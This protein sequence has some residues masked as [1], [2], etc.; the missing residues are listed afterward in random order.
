MFLD[1]IRPLLEFIPT[2]I[3][4]NMFLAIAAAVSPI[5]YVLIN[6]L[7]FGIEFFASSNANQKCKSKD[8]QK[9]QFYLFI[10]LAGGAIFFFS[11]IPILNLITPVVGIIFMVHVS[12]FFLYQSSVTEIA[13]C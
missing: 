2:F 7:I 6:S 3:L 8:D 12:H 4:D 5:L 1:T 9:L 13:E 10:F 11:L